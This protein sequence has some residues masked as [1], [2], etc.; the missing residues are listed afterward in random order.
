MAAFPAYT[1]GR[2]K[3]TMFCPGSGI[4]PLAQTGQIA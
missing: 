3:K 1:V 2:I 4:F